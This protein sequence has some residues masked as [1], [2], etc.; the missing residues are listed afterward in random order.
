MRI[1]G[2]L[3]GAPWL[4]KQSEY[5]MINLQI[6]Q[7]NHN[8]YMRDRQTKS[9]K[10]NTKFFNDRKQ[11][12]KTRHKNEKLFTVLNFYGVQNCIGYKN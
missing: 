9:R 12:F 1:N 6:T 3:K 4:V 11:N 10:L 2:S 7:N 8:V 5:R